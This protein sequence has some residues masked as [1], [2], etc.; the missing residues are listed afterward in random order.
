[1]AKPTQSERKSGEVPSSAP[2]TEATNITAS[3][4]KIDNAKNT[5]KQA[6]STYNEARRTLQANMFAKRADLQAALTQNKLTLAQTQRDIKVMQKRMAQN[7]GSE[8]VPAQNTISDLQNQANK[9]ASQLKSKQGILDDLNRQRRSLEKQAQMTLEQGKKFKQDEEAIMAAFSGIKDPE[10]VLAF[11][12]AHRKQIDDIKAG[13]KKANRN[14]AQLEE[15][16]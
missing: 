2:K 3:S 8:L 6:I 11:A 9:I 12:D 7:D 5:L 13:E 15:A 14:A 4:A 1:M 16:A 10:K